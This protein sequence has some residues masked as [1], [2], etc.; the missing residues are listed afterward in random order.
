M[1]GAKHCP[2]AVCRCAAA[3]WV[4]RS[5]AAGEDGIEVLAFGPHHEDDAETVED[6]WD[7]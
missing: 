4:T 7:D 1:P 2:C 3:P 5:L 6:N